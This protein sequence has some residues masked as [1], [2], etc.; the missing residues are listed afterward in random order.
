MAREELWHIYS[1]KSQLFLSDNNRIWTTGAIIIPLAFGAV[2][3]LWTIKDVTSAQR[4][5]SGLA[6]FGLLLFWNFFA[7]R[8]RILQK[9]SEAWLKAIDS[10][11][12][13]PFD[14]SADGRTSWWSSIRGMRWLFAILF[15][16]YALSNFLILVFTGS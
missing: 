13:G 14:D 10:I 6:G 5:G 16:L 2:A 12:G 9:R 4:V 11:H 7:D 8:Q 15:A 3:A 1:A